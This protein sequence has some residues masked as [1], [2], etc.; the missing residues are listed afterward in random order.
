MELERWA[1]LSAAISAVAVGFGRHKG[2]QH[3]TAVIVRVHTW[4]ALHDRPVSWAC[5]PRNWKARTRPAE[6]PDQSTMSRRTRRE[7]FMAFLERVG[8]RLNG[9]AKPGVGGGGGRKA[10]GV[11]QPQH[12]P[13]R[14]LVARRGPHQPG[15]QVAR[16][17]LGEP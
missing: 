15:V 2:D 11:A 1:E 3:S 6:L 5:D 16:G 13:R 8:E 7:D 9:K 14:H 17:F 4:A 10:A 12:R